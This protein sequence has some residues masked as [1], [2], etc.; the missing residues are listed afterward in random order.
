MFPPAE[1]KSKLVKRGKPRRVAVFGVDGTIFRSSL[2]IE[3]VD[4]L[5]QEG[6]FPANVPKE[7]NRALEAWLERRGSYED[8]IYS[9]VRVFDKHL[10]G[11]AYAS[12]LRIAERVALFHQNRNYRFTRDLVRTLKKKNYYL[13]A[14][15][16]SPKTVLD[17]FC[18]KLGFDKIYGRI[19]ESD[20]KDVLTGNVVFGDVIS[21]KGKVLS[22]AVEKENLTLKG[23]VGVGD[24]EGDIPF[25]KMVE[26][27]IC[28][29]PNQTLY[30][31]AKRRSWQIVV[32]RK[33]VIYK[34]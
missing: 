15:S 9:V 3:F 30:A 22:R 25:L 33:D 13:L 11:I 26:R 20:E 18:K 27:P 19:Y 34:L 8:Y 24:S 23:S 29:N 31:H 14:V 6:I 16:N 17:G 4:A 12:F 1:E 2:L 32:E 7:Y 21:D 5:W 10:K 28:F